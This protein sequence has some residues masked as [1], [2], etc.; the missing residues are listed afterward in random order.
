[1]CFFPIGVNAGYLLCITII[2]IVMIVIVSCFFAY[3]YY[4]HHCLPVI[5]IM[6]VSL[7]SLLFHAH[8]LAF[9]TCYL[10]TIIG[11]LRGGWWF[12]QSSLRFPNLPQGIL[13]VPQSRPRGPVGR[14]PG[15]KLAAPLA[16]GK[17]ARSGSGVLELM[18]K[19]ETDS[20]LRT[21]YKGGPTSYKWSYYSSLSR[22]I[23]PLTQL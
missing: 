3:H 14:H 6:L 15:E 22:V 19:T 2:V 9:K 20:R 5:T 17:V 13:R 21:M 12:P 11:F 7:L 10:L 4:I 8:H 23:T 1:M 18:G 16:H